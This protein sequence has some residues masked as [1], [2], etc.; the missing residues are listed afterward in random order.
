[1]KRIYLLMG[2]IDYEGNDPLQAFTSK[3]AAESAAKEMNDIPKNW[4]S[5]I[6]P[7]LKYGTFR[8][9]AYSVSDLDLDET[10]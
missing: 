6:G 7:A 3:D 2:D 9:D 10:E 1:M 5:S 8:Y 4:R